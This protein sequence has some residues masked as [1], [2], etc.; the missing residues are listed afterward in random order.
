MEAKPNLRQ[1]RQLVR[2]TGGG[3]Q[4]EEGGRRA[5]E[6]RADI[7]LTMRAY[8]FLI[9][10]L[11]FAAGRSGDVPPPGDDF[12]VAVCISGHVRSFGTSEHVG[13]SI[14]ENLLERV[15]GFTSEV[16]D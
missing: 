4:H 16:R 14:R 7:A 8:A 15:A 13:A 12:S 3:A 1:N 10:A 9:A 6:N 2:P 11:Q 5:A